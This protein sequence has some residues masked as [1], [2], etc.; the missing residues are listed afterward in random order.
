MDDRNQIP[1]IQSS[2]L[3]ASYSSATWLGFVA[4]LRTFKN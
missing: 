3:S 4:Q 1:R 2:G